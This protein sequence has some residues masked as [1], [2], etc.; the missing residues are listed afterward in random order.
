MPEMQEFQMFHDVFA[1]FGGQTV[2]IKELTTITMIDGKPCWTY[3]L[4]FG[5]MKHGETT[6]PR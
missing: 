2:Q 1:F 6:Y 4:L 5:G 3:Y